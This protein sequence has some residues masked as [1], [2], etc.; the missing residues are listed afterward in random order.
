MEEEP[1]LESPRKMSNLSSL[2]GAEPKRKINRGIRTQRRP[3]SPERTHPF[4]ES[5]EFSD[6]KILVICG[7]SSI[8]SLCVHF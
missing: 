7:A 6:V 4:M 8:F 3:K 5:D 2:R 1:E